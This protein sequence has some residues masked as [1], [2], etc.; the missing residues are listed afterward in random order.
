MKIKPIDS[1][2]TN[3]GLSTTNSKPFPI[4]GS[5]PNIS[6]FKKIKLIISDNTRLTIIKYDIGFVSLFIVLLKLIVSTAIRNEAIIGKPG[7]NQVKFNNIVIEK[8]CFYK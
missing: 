2:T 4:M 1:D 7:I 5:T 6:F 8:A 3:A